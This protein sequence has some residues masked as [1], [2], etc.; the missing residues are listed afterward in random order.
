MR[1]LLT[2]EEAEWG[3][4]LGTGWVPP[5]G[6]DSG[7]GAADAGMQTT[8]NVLAKLEAP[9]AESGMSLEQ[10]GPEAQQLGETMLPKPV[11]PSHQSGKPVLVQSQK[12]AAVQ[13]PSLATSK[14]NVTGPEATSKTAASR[15]GQQQP[16]LPPPQ[17]ID[18]MWV[19]PVHSVLTL[20]E[21]RLAFDS[22]PAGAR[23]VVLATNIAETSIT[24][25]DAVYVVDAG[26][27][28]Q[29]M[30]DAVN[31][32]QVLGLTWISK[33]SAKQRR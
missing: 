33:A 1:T 32:M 22:P 2:C 23:K 5:E 4:L 9:L 24:I 27:A 3:A 29:K 16:V 13:Q 26:V 6:A 7:G 14:G 20:P 28:R 25:P 31:N 12:S 8:H 11:V 17:V 18:G 21:Q 30:F 10:P 15:S 19:V